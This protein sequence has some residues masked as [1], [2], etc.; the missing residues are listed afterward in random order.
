MITGVLSTSFFAEEPH[1]RPFIENFA[2]RSL[3]RWTY[4]AYA[5]AILGQEM[6]AWKIKDYQAVCLT[7]VG[8]EAV[9]IEACAGIRR[10]EWQEELDDTLKAWARSLGK[11]RIIATVRPGWSKFGRSRGYREVHREMALEL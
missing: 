4:E 10:H 11:K 9:N 5:R 7:T 2:K 1:L 3:G 6:Q 8:P